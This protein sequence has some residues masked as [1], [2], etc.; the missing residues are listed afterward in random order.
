MFLIREKESA[1][2]CLQDRRVQRWY[3]VVGLASVLAALVQPA[4]AADVDQRAGSLKWI[5]ADAA[6]YGILMPF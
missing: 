5:P 6:F 4:P 2:A 3:L 1:M